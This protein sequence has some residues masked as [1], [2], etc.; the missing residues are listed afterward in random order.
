MVV[1]KTHVRS[2]GISSG[3]IMR[4]RHERLGCMMCGLAAISESVED[5][6]SSTKRTQGA[7][8]SRSIDREDREDLIEEAGDF[9]GIFAVC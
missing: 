1:A 4:D 6:G 2:Q 9:S 7:A 8:F 3:D 5:R